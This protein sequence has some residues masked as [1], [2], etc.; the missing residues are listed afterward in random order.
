MSGYLPGLVLALV[1]L[2]GLPFFR[3]ADTRVRAVVL[4]LIA[5]TTIRYFYWRVSVTL[6]PFRVGVWELARP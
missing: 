5:V 1:A 4:A 2:V 3:P 6:P